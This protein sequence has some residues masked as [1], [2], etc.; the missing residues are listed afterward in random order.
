MYKGKKIAAVIPAYN[1]ETQ[2]GKVLDSMPDFV[3]HLVVIDDRSADNTAEEIRQK[4]VRDRRITLLCHEANQGVGGAI[5]TGYEWARDHGVDVAVVMAGDGQMDP[6]D[7]PA[8]LD[9]VVSGATDYAKGNRLFT[10]EAY[11]KIPRLRYFG[12]AA[13]SFLTK[14]VSGYWHVADSQCGYTAINRAALQ[15]ID[16]SQMYKRYGQPND[17]LTRL[18]VY[19]FRVKDIYIEPV[20]RIGERSKMKIR[21]VVFTIAL[22]LMRLFFWRIKEKY[23]IR[24]FHPL[25]LFYALGFFLLMLS[26]VFFVQLVYLWHQR[27]FAPEL[28][29]LAWMFSFATGLQSIFFA[30]WFDKDYNRNS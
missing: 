25:V 17:L 8:I 19:N 13:L 10:G 28:T 20:Y 6:G 27:G 3:D 11:Q 9:P 5:A 15:R 29:A 24:D 23:I 30:M 21:L 2:I 4:R 1:E 12:N 14:I 18:N 26:F 16:W 7:L 22:L